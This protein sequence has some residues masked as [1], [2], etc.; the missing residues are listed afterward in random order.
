MSE[1]ELTSSYL[2]KNFPPV[3]GIEFPISRPLFQVMFGHDMHIIAKTARTD[4]S[5]LTDVC[6]SVHTTAPQCN[7]HA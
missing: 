3:N 7:Y 2:P 4:I 6:A 5:I 1:I